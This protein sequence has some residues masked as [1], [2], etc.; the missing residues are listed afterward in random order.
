MLRHFGTIRG[1]ILAIVAG[2]SVLTFLVFIALLFYPGGPPSPPWPW[3][4]TYRVASLVQMLRGTPPAERE[5][6]LIAAQPL[7][8]AMRLVPAAKPC[9]NID[10]DARDLQ[11]TVRA[12]LA[13]DT[14]V[15]ARSCAGTG[16]VPDIQ[17]LVPLG[18]SVLE[19]R[20]ARVGR[21]PPRLS[22]PFF[23]ALLF[24]CIGVA[25]L[26][27]WAA[28]RVVR[29]LRRLSDQAEAFGRDII[30]API[31]EEG[32]LEIRRAA[33]AFNLMQERITASIQSRTRMLAA[34]SHD[35]RTPLTR[36][37]LQLE[38]DRKDISREK[39]VHDIG[40]LQSMVTSALAFLSSSSQTEKKEWLD[41]GALLST[42]CDDYE[43][44][45]ARIAY[46]GPGKIPFLCR[47]EA[48][49][50]VMSNLIDN[51]LGFG[52][53]VEVSASVVGEVITIEVADNGPGIPPERLADVL[54]PFFRLDPSRSGRPG[55]VGLGL[56]IV[57]DIVLAHNGTLSLANRKPSGLVA[58]VVF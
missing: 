13:D 35:L 42:L 15:V 53:V 31:R 40:L 29:P 39:L 38:T 21:E 27:A 7:G 52:T 25:A 50:R 48:I 49:Q 30:V 23:G 18:D 45:G 37:R 1:Q 56:S 51:A 3:Q 44:T 43:D 2:S 26:S 19:V 57:H 5:R 54:E 6:L 47:P 36:M 14:E 10:F 11:A 55:S 17:L 58:R 22:F 9:D 34:V 8:L 4:T 12:E 41:L 16:A 32:P 46:Q 24:L 20:T 28:L 33:H